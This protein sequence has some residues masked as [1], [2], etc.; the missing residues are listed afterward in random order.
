MALDIAMGGSTNTVL[1]ILAAAQEGGVDFTMDDIDAL[2]RRVPCLCKVAPNK[3]DVHIE[4]VHR[5]GGIMSILGELDRGGLLHR[6][7]RTVHAPT[8]GAAIDQWD[9]G[10]SN[11]PEAR[12]LFLAAPG[13][14][15]TQVAFSQSS[16]WDTLD[17]DRETGVI[18]SVATPLLEGRRPRGAEGQP[19][20]RRLHRENGGRGR[21][22]PRLR[23]A[24][25]GVREPGRGRLRH[26]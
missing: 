10:R 14:V 24:R 2:S 15:P 13:G 17:T 23:R 26:P 19:R 7:T 25:Q 11:A 1:H 20:A 4:D 18:R 12:E 21:V 22:D 3:A 8:L 5:A 9:I 6:D 16:T